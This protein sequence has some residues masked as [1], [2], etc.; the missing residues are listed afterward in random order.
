MAKILKITELRNHFEKKSLKYK[1]D[2]KEQSK[3]KFYLLTSY[4]RYFALNPFP[5]NSFKFTLEV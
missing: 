2:T 1:Y 4:L 5:I 3:L